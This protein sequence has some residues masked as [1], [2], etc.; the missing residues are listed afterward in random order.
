MAKY[1]GQFG[2]PPGT[3]ATAEGDK[4]RVD[5]SEL[6]KKFDADGDGKLNKEE[7]A[8]ARKALESKDP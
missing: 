3:G 7:E 2:G 4:P 8:A 1:R 6:I 5:K